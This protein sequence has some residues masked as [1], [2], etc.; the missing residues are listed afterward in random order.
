MDRTDCIE[1]PAPTRWVII[2]ELTNC[3]WMPVMTDRTQRTREVK[4]AR[5]TAESNSS[6]R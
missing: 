3:S 5:M 2:G 4:Q 1:I 6:S